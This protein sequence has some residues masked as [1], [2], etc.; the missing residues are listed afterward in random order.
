MPAGPRVLYA[1][2][3]P[4]RV[5][6]IVERHVRDGEPVDFGKKVTDDYDDIGEWP[7]FLKM[8]G[9]VAAKIADAAG[10][11]I[12][13]GECDVT[14]EEA[15]RDVLAAE[16]EGT[17]GY[18]DITGIPWIEIDFPEDLSRAEGIT[19]QQ[20]TD[21]VSEDPGRTAAKKPSLRR[22]IPLKPLG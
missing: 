19:Y 18:E 21:Y 13:R 2:V 3:G 12:E 11:Y 20:V 8:S 14:Y 7:G 4:E 16:P 17:F 5:P 6:E 22:I 9:D 15:M 10:V 1:N